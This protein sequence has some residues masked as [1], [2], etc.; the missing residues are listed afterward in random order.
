MLMPF[1]G[2]TCE[3]RRLARLLDKGRN[4]VL[5]GVYGSGRTTL[6]RQLAGKERSRQF[7]F[8]DSRNSQRALRITVDKVCAVRATHDI[9]AA[10]NLRWSLSMTSSRSPRSDCAHC[11][12]WCERIGARS[13]RLS[14]VQCPAAT[15]HVFASLWTPR[16]SSVLAR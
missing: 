8:W 7:V 12:S 1:V 5:T 16:A 14:G 10:E 9:P 4:V 6:L 3:L 15:S 11:G 2:R 13:S